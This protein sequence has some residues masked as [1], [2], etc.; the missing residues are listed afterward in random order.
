MADEKKRIQITIQSYQSI[1]N[2]EKRVYSFMNIVLP[3]SVSYS[4]LAYFSV[5][6]ILMFLLNS[7]IG[8]PAFVP[9]GFWFM[10]LFVGVPAAVTRFGR[11]IQLDG[12]STAIFLKDY[13]QFLFHRRKAFEGL[14]PIPP[15]EAALQGGTARW[16][17]TYKSY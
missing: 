14:R 3:M 10:L 17:C 15:A 9:A 4:D 11:K 16:K 6:E 12:K 13:I 8:R 5:T 1:F 2:Y 7:A